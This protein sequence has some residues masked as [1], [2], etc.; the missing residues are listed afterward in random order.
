MEP[1]RGYWLNMRQPASRTV[2]GDVQGPLAVSLDAGWNLVGGGP[3]HLDVAALQG[4]YPEVQQV[5]DYDGGY[6]QAAVMEPGHGYW[7]RLS[8][9]A[10]VDLSNVDAAAAKPTRALL[11]QAPWDGSRLWAAAAGGGL[12]QLELGAPPERAVP[13]PPLPPAG[14]L[15]LRAETAAGGTWQVPSSLTDAVT[16]VR[17]QGQQVTLGWEVLP[18]D[19]GR[20]ELSWG[21]R[22]VLLSGVGALPVGSGQT[23]M[24]LRQVTGSSATPAGVWLAQ[25]YPNPFNP[26]T[27][28]Q[29]G[30][31][32]AAPVELSIYNQAGQRIARLAQG[33]WPAG[34]HQV[35]WDGRDEVGQEVG[36]GTYVCRL[37]SGNSVQTRKL[38]L[39]R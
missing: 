34:T 28:I 10:Q 23:L 16:P 20:W 11:A 33:L 25:N 6:L 35:E 38:V 24:E 9:P 19:D 4:L 15:D 29:F 26:R 27:A 21:D 12:Q 39:V 36:S 31:A 32:A 30:L 18:A 14:A 7:M 13:L 8:S 1:G 17:V 37:A 3:L 2:D 22:R 5:F